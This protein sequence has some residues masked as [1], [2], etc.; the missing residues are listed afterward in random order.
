MDIN[1]REWEQS[2]W[3]EEG[4]RETSGMICLSLQKHG[5]KNRKSNVR[6]ITRERKRRAA[7]REE[8]KYLK[9]QGG[10]DLDVLKQGEEIPVGR[11]K[12]ISKKAKMMEN[13]LNP[14]NIVGP[15]EI[16]GEAAGKE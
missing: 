10:P 4:G 6:G 2:L 8:K 9:K 13:H 15:T 11:N 12:K 1:R 7:N 3:S 16:G 5:K 14:P